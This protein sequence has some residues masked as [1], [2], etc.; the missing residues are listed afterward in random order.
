MS[1]EVKVQSFIYWFK[2]S[3][4]ITNVISSTEAAKFRIEFSLYVFFK[5][6]SKQ[7]IIASYD[8]IVMVLIANDI[9]PPPLQFQF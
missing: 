7:T 3:W 5:F 9:L 4:L 8:L 2:A 1:L 6:V